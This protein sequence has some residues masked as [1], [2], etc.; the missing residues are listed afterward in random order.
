MSLSNIIQTSPTAL[1]P[2]AKIYCQGIR[3]S[4]TVQSVNLLIAGAGES[5]FFSKI[6]A[7]QFARFYNDV[8]I[9]GTL[10]VGNFAINNL[11]CDN[12]TVTNNLTVGNNISCENVNV[13]NDLNVADTITTVN[14]QCTN[15]SITNNLTVD[16]NITCDN[17]NVNNNLNVLENVDVGQNVVCSNLTC[18]NN[19]TSST[20]AQLNQSATQQSNNEFLY[21]GKQFVPPVLNT[22]DRDSIGPTDGCFLFNTDVQNLQTYY[23][24]IWRNI[25]YWPYTMSYFLRS[26]EGCANATNFKIGSQSDWKTI[27]NTDSNEEYLSYAGS[28]DWKINKSAFYRLTITVS[29]QPPTPNFTSL[30]LYLCAALDGTDCLN[31]VGFTDNTGLYHFPNK[32]Q[33]YQLVTE[34]FLEAGRTLS[35]FIYQENNT[36][37]SFTITTSTYLPNFN[38]PFTTNLQLT[39]ISPN[40]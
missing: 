9:D 27:Y 28:G 10:T 37:D 32:D 14:I 7:Y 23:S 36:G 2:S 21:A 31:Y 13:A 11:T 24:S 25:A 22:G 39:M 20:F 6:S 16:H 38:V 3:C 29:L 5:S 1:P 15:Q 17:I 34:C 18:Y 19:L 4:N 26:D 35:F 8:T 40:L 30:T 33:R 12:A